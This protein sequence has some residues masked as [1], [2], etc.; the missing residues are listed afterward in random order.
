MLRFAELL[1]KLI[2]IRNNFEEGVS[3]DGQ[4]LAQGGKERVGG[5]FAG[6]D[7][8]LKNDPAGSSGYGQSFEALTSD[9]IKYYARARTA[10][11]LADPIGQI[12]FIGHDDVV[13]PD[14]EQLGLL[15]GGARGSDAGV[16]RLN[17]H[18][19]MRKEPSFVMSAPSVEC[20]FSSLASVDQLIRVNGIT[21]F[22]ISSRVGALSLPTSFIACA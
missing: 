14:C 4:V 8:V 16:W 18:G 15:F 12:F 17:S 2:G 6:Q 13:G 7:A 3:L 21:N 1:R 10:G 5:R 22:R 19:V 11:N 9:W 20:R